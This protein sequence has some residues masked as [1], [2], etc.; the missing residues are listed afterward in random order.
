LPLSKIQREDII[1][2]IIHQIG[3]GFADEI[4]RVFRNNYP[5]IELIPINCTTAVSNMIR[6]VCP[7]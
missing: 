1:T 3:Q 2:E 5:E 4:F 6:H 7:T